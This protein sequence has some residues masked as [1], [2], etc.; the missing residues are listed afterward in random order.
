MIAIVSDLH[1][2]DGTS[3]ET[4]RVGAFRAFRERLRDM[5]YDASWRSDGKY[6][7][8][9]D[10]HLVLLGDILD[11]IRSNKWPADPGAS[12]YVRPWDDPQSPKFVNKIAAITDAI[13]ANNMDSLAVLRSL[14]DGEIL[15][16]P[17]ATR[18]GKPAQ[19]SRDPDS[20]G[21]VPVKVHIHY[22]VGNH[23]WF[24]HLPGLGY[25]QIRKRIVE[26]MGL[27][28][29]P[30]AP[31]PHDPSE[32]P[33]IEAAYR[34]HALFARHGDIFDEF[35]FDGDRNVSSL[36]DAIVIDLLNRFPAEVEAKMGGE[37][38]AACIAGLRE[39]DN[40]RPLL[41]IPVWVDS[42]LR[43]TC[44]DPS[45]IKRVKDIWDNLA[46]QFLNIPFV[47]QH[48]SVFKL[49]DS[50]DKLELVLKFSCG[51]S[52]HTAGA[53]LTWVREKLATGGDDFYKFA[54]TER[55]FKDRTAQY[56]VYG[57]THHYEVVPLDSSYSDGIL[58]NQMYLNSGTWRQVHE[59]A[60]LNPKDQEFMGYKV[61]T[62]FGFFK[63]DERAGRRFESWSGA[64][65][66]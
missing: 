37:L 61:M 18:D 49:F 39:I 42:L 29:S 1:L 8:I 6:Q 47:R 64:L 53:L 59:L 30:D 43:R 44:S 12:D 26:A 15:T 52:L 57:H 36:G 24:F 54:F 55:A 51:V 58:F 3:G 33:V 14:N 13:L 11:V 10:L 40:V 31:F 9:D 62:Y 60:E 25:N 23:D 19:V 17:P 21:R 50:F 46:D 4:I 35:N 2:T 22:L 7:P 56:I 48:N 28:N 27:A 32:S 16:I 63:K 5:A 66:S 45:Q 65:G 41:V 20:P 34:E 38:P